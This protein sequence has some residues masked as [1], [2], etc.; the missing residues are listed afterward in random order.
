MPTCN[1]RVHV[2]SEPLKQFFWIKHN[3]REVQQCLSQAFLKLVM[4]LFVN[5]SSKFELQQDTPRVNGDGQFVGV[6]ICFL[7]QGTPQSRVQG[8][9]QKHWGV[10]YR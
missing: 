9:E 7:P 8:D 2:R 4:L 5:E 3:V 6:T 1:H 10:T